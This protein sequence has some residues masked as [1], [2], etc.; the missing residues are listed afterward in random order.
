MKITTEDLRKIIQEELGS[1]ML[2]ELSND[3]Y[4]W[5][6]RVQ[7]EKLNVD[8]ATEILFS[9]DPDEEDKIKKKAK[10]L[11]FNGIKNGIKSTLDSAKSCGRTT[12]M[13]LKK[14]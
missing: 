12:T 1:V 10:P 13:P 6:A 14:C 7:H 9:V 2:E 4:Y 3:V 11:A 5:S 8:Y